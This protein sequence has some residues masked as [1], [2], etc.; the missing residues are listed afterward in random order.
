MNTEMGKIAGM[1]E[2]KGVQTPLQQ[3]LAALGKY[4]GIIALTAC[5]IIFVIGLLNK[6]S[7][8]DI[9]MTSVSLAVSAIPEDCPQSL[10]LF[11]QSVFSVWLSKM[12][13]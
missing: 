10:P 11:Y 12:R 2:R 5:A 13:L 7:L 6:I 4:L 8:M 9:F 3:R 1:L